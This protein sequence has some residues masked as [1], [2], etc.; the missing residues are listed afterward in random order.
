[1]SAYVIWIDS[2]EAKLFN[3]SQKGQS[4]KHIHAHGHKHHKD[5]H[6]KH[7]EKHHPESESVFKDLC[8]L[9]HDA[10]EVL[11]IGPGE[12]KTA[13]K[14]YLDKHFSTTLAKKVVGVETVDH[15]T[16]PQIKE[17]ARK[18]FKTFDLFH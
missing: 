5:P 1:M 7:S 17:I 4:P 18:F 13:F 8:P 14:S 3:L 11:L 10:S 6:G 2:V 16:E 9:I 15:P 12:A